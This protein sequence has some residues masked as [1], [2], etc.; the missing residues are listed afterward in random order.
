MVLHSCELNLHPPLFPVQNAQ[1]L[2]HE[3]QY[4]ITMCCPADS[5]GSQ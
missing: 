4:A 2:S 1:S 3:V 5:L